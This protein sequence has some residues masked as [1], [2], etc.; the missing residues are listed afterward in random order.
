[1]G[2]QTEG[3]KLEMREVKETSFLL[4]GEGVL[5]PSL[6]ASYRMKGAAILQQTHYSCCNHKLDVFK[7]GHWWFYHSYEQWVET[8]RKHWSVSS[9]S[10][11]KDCSLSYRTMRRQIGALIQRGA[12][13]V[14]RYTQG[15][16]FQVSWYRV[17]YEQVSR[18]LNALHPDKFKY[19]LRLDIPPHFY[20]TFHQ[21]KVLSLDEIAGQD[22]LLQLAAKA[23]AMKEE[24]ELKMLKTPKVPTTIAKVQEKL[25][26]A[27]SEITNEMMQDTS[28]KGLE[29]LWQKATLTYH[30]DQHF[31]PAWIGKNYGQ[32]KTWKKIIPEDEIT[33]LIVHTLKN[34]GRFTKHVSKSTGFK[35]VFPSPGMDYFTQHIGWAMDMYMGD[36]QPKGNPPQVIAQPVQPPAI[37]KVSIT[38]PVKKA[39]EIKKPVNP[40]DVPMSE[41]ELLAFFPVKGYI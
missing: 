24:N 32:V 5:H 10:G 38:I 39:P 18:D 36:T 41:E 27:S 11:H 3:G 7:D 4:A 6:V 22:E 15:P 25:S 20:P 16:R 37:T 8:F 17:N 13:I 34:W 2:A 29:K 1:M 12:L 9:K 28:N 23:Q 35:N 26:S 30:K 14:G 19:E 21:I 33:K 40:E 31:V